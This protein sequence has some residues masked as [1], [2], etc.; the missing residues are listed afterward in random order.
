MPEISSGEHPKQFV[1]VNGKRMAYVELGSG[2][3][4]IFLH[5]NPTSSYLWRNIMP[6]V[7]DA[8]RAI[9]LVPMFTLLLALGIGLERPD[10]LRIFGV[11]I[12]FVSMVLIA[13]PETSLPEPEK[14]I[15]VL[16]ALIAVIIDRRS[17]LI[18]AVGY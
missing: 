10:Y 2:D 9:A 16:V 12:G 11:V 3:P 4:V 6:H 15:F 13:A 18:A 14:A 8:H 1:E 5:G 7:S 17:F